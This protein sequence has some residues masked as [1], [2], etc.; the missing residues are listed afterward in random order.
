MH[1][2]KP[3]GAGGAGGAGIQLERIS[4]A[5]ARQRGRLGARAESGGQGKC[6]EERGKCERGERIEIGQ[7][8]QKGE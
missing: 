1:E 4:D 2:K 8:D 6:K 3:N 7:L 5:A